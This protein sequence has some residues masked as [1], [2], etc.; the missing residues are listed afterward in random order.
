MKKW[1]N[2]KCPSGGDQLR[3]CFYIPTADSQSVFNVRRSLYLSNKETVKK[4]CSKY[5][6]HSLVHATI[7][8]EPV[9]LSTGHCVLQTRDGSGNKQRETFT[10]L[11]AVL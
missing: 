9:S 7:F 2:P 5:V 11:K 10:V 1:E 6:A 4:K 3:K 8:T